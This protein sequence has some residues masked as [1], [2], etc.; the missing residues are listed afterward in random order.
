MV[1][2]GVA[3]GQQSRIINI[4]RNKNDNLRLYY[5]Y[6]IPYIDISKCQYLYSNISLIQTKNKVKETSIDASFTLLIILISR[7]ILCPIR[8]SSFDKQT[9]QRLFRDQRLLLHRL[10]RD[11]HSLEPVLHH[12]Q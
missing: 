11:N 7:L 4:L 9:W 5:Y 6:N 8:C 2:N 10:C 3:I 12:L 1:S